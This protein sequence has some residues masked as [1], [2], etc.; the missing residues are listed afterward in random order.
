MSSF[1]FI[2]DGDEEDV[3]Q[4]QIDQAT[5]GD[6]SE[7]AAMM[8]EAE[9]RFAKAQYFR[10]LITGHLFV[11][12][13]S[14]LAM[15]VSAEV[16]TFCRER[17]AVLLGIKPEPKA[18]VAVKSPFDDDEIE[19]LKQVAGKLLKKPALLNAPAAAPVVSQA[20]SPRTPQVRQSQGQAPAPK[21]Q[22]PTQKPPAKAPE[23][24]APNPAK[25]RKGS[26]ATGKTLA[27]P[28]ADNTERVYTEMVDP[29]GNTFWMGSNGMHYELATNESGQ[30]YMRSLNRQA[31]PV[32][33]TPI[34]QLTG[35]M[36][37]MVAARQTQTAMEQDPVASGRAT[38][39]R[40]VVVASN[41]PQ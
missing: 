23:K 17:L 32:G 34:P 38:G 2:G 31:R 6:S 33:V 8:S 11:N 4:A 19:V 5:G 3:T 13:Y 36:M 14:D 41:T 7:V 9:Q 25:S 35:D 18:A 20:A 28:Q 15:A 10:S 30:N 1:N 37:A 39:G 21:A 22:V 26:N 29:K 12:D 27:I 40:A 24:P 16:Q